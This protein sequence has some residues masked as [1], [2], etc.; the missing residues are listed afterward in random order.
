MYFKYSVV[1]GTAVARQ[2]VFSSL[3]CYVNIPSGAPCRALL[4]VKGTDRKI[5]ID[6]PERC[7]YVSGELTYDDCKFLCMV[8]N[9][10]A[11]VGYAYPPCAAFQT[12]APDR[13]QSTGECQLIRSRRNV[14]DLQCPEF[15]DWELMTVPTSLAIPNASS[16][17]RFQDDSPINPNLPVYRCFP[18]FDAA[19]FEVC[20]K[21]PDCPAVTG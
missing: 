7:K 17:C 11:P 10:N 3:L 14:D 13:S 1:A 12:T 2:T 20:P 16:I 9:A 4:P 18:I 5:Q 19:L 15:G 6:R 21:I 8:W